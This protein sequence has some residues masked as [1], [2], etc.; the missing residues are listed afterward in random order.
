MC[1]QPSTSSAVT[2]VVITSRSRRQ[3]CPCGRAAPAL[4][5][6]CTGHYQR[7][8]ARE[9]YYGPLYAT[10]HIQ[11]LIPAE[12][13]ALL[14]RAQRDQVEQRF[15]TRE[16]PWDPNLLSCT[17]TLEMGINIGDLS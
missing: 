6:R 4:R 15:I 10:G 1:T 7:E 13:T 9:D 16:H 3:K 5:R 17:P 8:P 11:R 2:P 14:K 12:H